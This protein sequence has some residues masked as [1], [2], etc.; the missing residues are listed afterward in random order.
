MD[1]RAQ[2]F[3]PQTVE[4]SDFPLSGNLLLP[5]VNVEGDEFCLEFS[6]IL[7]NNPRY[8]D[9]RATNAHTLSLVSYYGDSETSLW[10]RVG[11]YGER[12]HLAQVA[13]GQ[14]HHNLSLVYRISSL[15]ESNIP[16]SLII[17]VQ[18]QVDDFRL[19]KGKCQPSGESTC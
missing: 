18:V 11:N 9:D 4:P 12:W 6:F 15:N 7:Y 1:L 5:D 17:G 14:G 3:S 2:E 8:I 13:L 19:V 16:D 10:T